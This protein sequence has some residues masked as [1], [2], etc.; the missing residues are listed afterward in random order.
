M[1]SANQYY[2][3]IVNCELFSCTQLTT[4]ISCFQALELPSHISQ[5]CRMTK[6]FKTHY[7]AIITVI[8]RGNMWALLLSAVI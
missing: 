7:K 8:F 2:R 5:D 3:E 4:P 1:F 6:L